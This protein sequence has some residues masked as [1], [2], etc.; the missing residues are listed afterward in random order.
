M[1][2]RQADP[3]THASRR[4]N[5]N[6]VACPHRLSFSFGTLDFLAIEAAHI[7]M[8]CAGESFAD[9]SGSHGRRFDCSRGRADYIRLINELHEAWTEAHVAIARREQQG[10]PAVATLTELLEHFLERRCQRYSKVLPKGSIREEVLAHAAR[11]RYELRDYLG[12]FQRHLIQRCSQIAYADRG[13][14][15]GRHYSTLFSPRVHYAS[16]RGRSCRLRRPG[17]SQ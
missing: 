9:A 13:A 6:N 15:T 8:V 5:P 14:W 16:R 1:I 17:R 12:S 11:K 3:R 2:T 10:A 4:E 7:A